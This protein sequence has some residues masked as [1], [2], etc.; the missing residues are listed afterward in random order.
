M[1][2]GIG[3][4]STLSIQP[5]RV[6]FIVAGSIT[7]FAGILFYFLMPAGP[8][9]AWFLT[10]DE[11]MI[12]ARR[13]ASQHDGGDKTNFSVAQF[14]EACLDIKTFYVFMFGVLVTMCSPVL[15]FA[16]LVIKNLV[17]PSL[18]DCWKSIADFTCRVI[19]PQK[20]CCMDRPLEP[21]RSCSSG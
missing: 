7:V 1:M 3:E 20:H 15:T 4:N 12:A 10:A 16:S 14:Q 21:Y 11:K 17:R 18:I 8:A 9:T 5:W 19:H 13:L 2:Y 6:M